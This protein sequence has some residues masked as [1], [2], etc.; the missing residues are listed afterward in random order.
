[1]IAKNKPAFIMPARLLNRSIVGEINF[2]QDAPGIVSH[3]SSLQDQGGSFGTAFSPAIV[4]GSNEPVDSALLNAIENPRER[5][6]VLNL[7]NVL[8]LF[9][10]SRFVVYRLLPFELRISHLS[11]TLFLL[12][13]IIFACT[14][15]GQWNSRP[16]II[17]SEDFWLIE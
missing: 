10:K 1:M 9:I 17:L 4:S 14:V 3:T 8:L 7:E 15:I 11:L 6:H 16:N 2:L 5:M 12:L 13:I